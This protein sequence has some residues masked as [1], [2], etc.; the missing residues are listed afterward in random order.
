MSLTT[1]ERIMK[2]RYDLLREPKMIFFGSL[3]MHMDIIK[4]DE[5]P[6][7]AVNVKGQLLYNESFVNEQDKQGLRF[8]VAHEVMH[9]ATNCFTRRGSRDPFVWNV[10]NDYVINLLLKD[11]GIHPLEGALIDEKFRDWST[12]QIYDH[13]KENPE[14]LPQQQGCGSS[15]GDDDSE[16]GT[17]QQGSGHGTY[18][19]CC[20]HREV[21]DMSSSQKAQHKEEWKGKLIQA[22]Q[23]AEQRG[24]LP[25]S[26]KRMV[27]DFTQ[28]K[29]PWKQILKN[30]IRNAKLRT[31]KSFRRLGR[32]TQAVGYPVPSLTPDMGV[33]TI[34]LDTSGS[35][36]HGDFLKVALSEVKS[37][38]EELRCPLRFISV[39]ADVQADVETDDIFEMAENLIG[40]GGTDFVTLFNKL[41]KNPPCCLIFFSDL[42]AGYPSY[43]PQYPVLWIV[44]E[45]HGEA[46]FG[47]VLEIDDKTISETKKAAVKV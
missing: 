29:L 1:E 23:A 12:E 24:E 11:A 22:A 16:D 6:T 26:I 15:Q 46:P 13:F 10:A 3:A 30:T 42:W 7:T 8:L 32:R 43:T 21:S 9:L 41:Q 20:D 37:V 40:G 35:M 34:A 39:D 31:D 19:G 28:P 14:E 5:I 38:L 47:K 27:D 2:A 33:P 25:A 17:P 4:K 45:R 36:F 44:P 18:G